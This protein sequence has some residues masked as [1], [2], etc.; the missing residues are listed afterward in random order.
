MKLSTRKAKKS[1]MN[2]FFKYINNNELIEVLSEVSD[3]EIVP[4]YP[5][6]IDLRITN[7]CDHG[8]KFCFMDSSIKEKHADISFL[9]RV[10]ISIVFVNKNND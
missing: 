1:A 2:K 9:N 10:V 6:L 7:K 3:I 8:C 5:E 4:E